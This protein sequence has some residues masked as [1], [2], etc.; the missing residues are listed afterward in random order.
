MS[1]YKFVK[2]RA[3]S[4]LCLTG[5]L[6]T[7]TPAVQATSS[8]E[9]Y[10]GFQPMTSK[11]FI[12]YLNTEPICVYSTGFSVKNRA[13][14]W[15]KNDRFAVRRS[16]GVKTRQILFSYS[17][18]RRSVVPAKYIYYVVRGRLKVP[19]RE[20]LE[21]QEDAF[22]GRESCAYASTQEFPELTESELE[23][24]LKALGYRKDEDDGFNDT[25]YQ[26]PGRRSGQ[27]APVLI[28]DEI[29]RPFKGDDVR[30]VLTRSSLGGIVGAGLSTRRALK[31][32]NEVLG[33]GI[34]IKA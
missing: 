25:V 9:S 33:S 12:R 22:A 10:R 20:A 31:T 18:I 14:F 34:S 4:A 32:I 5:V 27:L 23:K 3:V 24:V 21:A 19:L 30:R 26:I 6:V 11:E 7:V 17:A 15:I 16:G 8:T 13:V 2:S 29:K 28:G 1:V